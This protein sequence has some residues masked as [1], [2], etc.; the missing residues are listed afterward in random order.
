MFGRKF[1]D[2]K[3]PFYPE[4]RQNTYYIL[5][6]LNYWK[7][8]MLLS[9]DTIGAKRYLIWNESPQSSVPNLLYRHID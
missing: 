7:I 1:E 5:K 6:I 4:N 8:K 3:S 9:I 2:I